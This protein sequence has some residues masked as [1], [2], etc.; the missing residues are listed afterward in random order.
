MRYREITTPE[1]ERR[2]EKLVADRVLNRLNAGRIYSD[3]VVQG[4]KGAQSKYI[5]QLMPGRTAKRRALLHRQ[6]AQSAS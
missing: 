3:A 2:L 5:A 6:N 1:L 4:L